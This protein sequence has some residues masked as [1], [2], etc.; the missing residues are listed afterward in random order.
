MAAEPQTISKSLAEAA[1][2]YTA[3]GF[4]VF[5]LHG[6]V[7]DSR[8]GELHCT[9]RL[10]ASCPRP[11]KHPLG[12]LAPHGSL[13]ATD[14]TIVVAEWW[15]QATFANVAV[16][17][18]TPLG[19][20]PALLGVVDVDVGHNGFHSLRALVEATPEA[21]GDWAAMRK[22]P[23]VATG[24]G[25]AHFYVATPPRANFAGAAGT[26][27]AGVDFRGSGGYVVAPPSRHISG[28][29]YRWAIPLDAAAPPPLPSPLE[30]WLSPVK[31][32]TASSTSARTESHIDDVADPLLRRRLAAYRDAVVAES[33]H[34]IATAPNGRRH[35][36]LLTAS[37]RI[38]D[39]A[40]RYRSRAAP[41]RLPRSPPSWLCVPRD[42]STTGTSLALPRAAMAPGTARRGAL[43]ARRAHA[44]VVPSA[45]APGRSTGA[46]PGSGRPHVDV[47]DRMR[48]P[49]HRRAGGQRSTRPTNEKDVQ[50]GDKDALDPGCR[51]GPR[52][53][54]AV[55]APG[56]LRAA[57]SLREA[58]T[59]RAHR[60]RR[61]R[62]PDRGQPG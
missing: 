34:L 1:A 23:Q 22:A 2:A 27:R 16:A 15:Q 47:M 39:L 59:P 50:D 20:G 55:G 7:S 40:R 30:E 41:R 49:R 43:D 4:K 38:F 5:P 18:G 37:R 28:A 25:G 8:S 56:D 44:L 61:H 17:T 11:G 33:A 36:A 35:M 57:C 45:T 6:M 62:C 31:E 51:R 48:V 53:H 9:C 54:A 60:R 3:R 29:R 10:G 42:P 32:P 58:R 19:E 24:G 26:D 46:Y 13:D 52:G 14:D 12:R 21:R